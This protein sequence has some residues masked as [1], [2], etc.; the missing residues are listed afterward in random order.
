MLIQSSMVRKTVRVVLWNKKEPISN[1]EPLSASS[2]PAS[3]T[4]IP[5]SND[6]YQIDEFVSEEGTRIDGIPVK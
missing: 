6:Y 2:E 3:E 1:K 5:D 4:P